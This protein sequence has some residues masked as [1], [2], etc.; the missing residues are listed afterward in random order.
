MI[1]PELMNVGEF[2]E[3]ASFAMDG[4]EALGFG[5]REAKGFDGANGEAGFVNAREDFAGESTAKG[6]GLD[7][8]ERAF[9][10]QNFLLCAIEDRST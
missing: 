3:E 2:A 10:G 4:V 9:N 8:G 5:L 7:D 1:L 6:V